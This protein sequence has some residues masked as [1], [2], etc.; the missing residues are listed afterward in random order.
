MPTLTQHYGLEKPDV[1]SDDDVWGGMMN[2][3]LDAIDALFKQF[4]DTITALDES[5][6][7]KVGD[8]Y[9]TTTATNP[10][11]S[12]G[13]GTWEPYAAGRAIVGVGNNGTRTW[14]GGM[15]YGADG[16]VLTEAELPQ[17][18]HQSDPPNQRFNTNV[19]GAHS[20]KLP[21]SFVNVVESG[22]DRDAYRWSITA[23]GIDT[24]SD[25]A[26]QHYV[27]VDLNAFWSSYV[28]ANAAHNNVQP[29]IGVYVWRRTE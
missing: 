7:I 26:H 16:H 18:R 6:K 5:R 4:N 25:G 20:H 3:T 15:E 24:S 8:L 10:A 23:T 11:T 9:L 13:Y 14:T 2:G 19:T 22:S 28:G 17:H 1:G 27:D 12:L 29:S 21:N